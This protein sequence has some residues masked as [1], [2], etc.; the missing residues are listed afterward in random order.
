V[1]GTPAAWTD[2]LCTGSD[3][4]FVFAKLCLV[5]INFHLLLFHF[6]FRAFVS[7]YLEF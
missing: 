5:G 2:S 6:G 7:V 4:G 1:I 3:E